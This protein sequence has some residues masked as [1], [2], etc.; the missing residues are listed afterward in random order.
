MIE[1]SFNGGS[2]VPLIFATKFVCPQRE[3]RRDHDPGPRNHFYVLF[4]QFRWRFLGP[5]LTLG[6][7]K[8]GDVLLLKVILRH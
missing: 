1:S 3:Q 7:T 6:A 8:G 4:K 2:L 5:K